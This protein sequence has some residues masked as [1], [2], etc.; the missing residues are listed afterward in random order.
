MSAI[1][2]SIFLRRVLLLDAVSS[3]AM[4]VLLLT[5]GGFLAGVLNLPVE[6]LN[7]AGIVL[8]PF[9]LILAFLGT[10]ARLMRAAVWAVIVV[11]AVWVID[12]C[13]LLL[14]A[15]LSTKWVEPT[16]LGYIFVA[17]QAA[18]VALMAELQFIGLR[19][20]K[21]VAALAQA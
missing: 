7:E 19:K 10:R 16:V 21:A 18:F 11:N 9:A 2:S 15:T 5:C 1:Q 6:L 4:G 17:G 3:G 12:S 8:M 13:V 14:S 20:S